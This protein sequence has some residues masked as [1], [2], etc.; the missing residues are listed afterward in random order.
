V[1]ACRPVAQRPSS[2][3]ARSGTGIP[4]F[5]RSKKCPMNLHLDAFEFCSAKTTLLR[6][7]LQTLFDKV[8]LHYFNRT[9]A[10]QMGFNKNELAT[11]AKTSP[12]GFAVEIHCADD[13]FWYAIVL[14]SSTSEK[15]DV[16]TARGDLKSWRNLD[17]AV[18]F[19]E[20]TTPACKSF[21]VR[22]GQWI[23][24]RTG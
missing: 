13:K 4:G 14:L 22:I 20:K 12:D 23:L 9:R 18:L 7:L 2:Y 1:A 6:Q 3:A 19:F 10:A 8:K 21:V 24:S 5:S 17:D 16:L 15:H 11:I